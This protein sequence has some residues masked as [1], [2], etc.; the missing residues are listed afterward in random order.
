MLIYH[1]Q[2]KTIPD[3]SIQGNCHTSYSVCSPGVIPCGWVTSKSLIYLFL[4]L[5]LEIKCVLWKALMKGRLTGEDCATWERTPRHPVVDCFRISGLA[6]GQAARLC[7]F[8]HIIP[9]IWTDFMYL[10]CFVVT[11]AFMDFTTLLLNLLLL[12]F[13]LSWRLQASLSMPF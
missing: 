9:W 1:Y 8:N 11:L 5:Y 13:I 2:G 6:R 3:I 4:V 10:V 7:C 12:A